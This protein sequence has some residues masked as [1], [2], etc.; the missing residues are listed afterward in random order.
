MN[1]MVAG[2]YTKMLHGVSTVEFVPNALHD[3]T[4]DVRHAVVFRGGAE[5]A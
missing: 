1:V 3:V 4:V 5:G 2:T